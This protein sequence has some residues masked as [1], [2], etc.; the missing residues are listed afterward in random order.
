MKLKKLERILIKQKT[1]TYT[2]RSFPI[3]WLYIWFKLNKL[4][5]NSI[6]INEGD[7][8]EDKITNSI[9]Q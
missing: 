2:G 1:S 6:E 5:N 7:F 9:I 3:Y 4:Y 8:N